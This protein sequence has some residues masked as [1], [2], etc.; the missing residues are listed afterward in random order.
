MNLLTTHDIWLF[1]WRYPPTYDER[2]YLPYIAKARTGDVGAI[3]ALTRWKNTSSAGKPM[4]F[5]RQKRAA[6]EYFC[7]GLNR[8]RGA[9]GPAAL[10]KDFRQR[11]PV[12]SIFWCHV[13]TALQSS[14][15]TPT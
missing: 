4:N 6:F 1:H 11:A 2:Y 5:S 8:Y 3:E 9:D 7:S 12:W 13:L 14:T 10:R 15:G